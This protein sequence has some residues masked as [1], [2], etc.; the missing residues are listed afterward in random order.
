MLRN[1]FRVDL[2]YDG[3][4]FAGFARQ[5]GQRTVEGQ[6]I[7]AWR[8]L[9]PAL[10]GVQ[11]GGRTDKGVHALRQ[12]VSFW[13]RRQL[14]LQA[15]EQAAEA[16][17][18]GSGWILSCQRVARSFHAKFSA[19]ARHYMY[20]LGKDDVPWAGALTAERAAC[21]DAMLGALVGVR[22]L[23]AFARR[24]PPQA[25]PVRHILFAG[26]RLRPG[27]GIRIDVLSR[28]FLRKQMRVTVATVLRESD[29]SDDVLALVRLANT[30]D[31]QATAP[32]APADG[33]YLA[34]IIYPE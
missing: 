28:G 18:G 31:R 20:L 12:T 23:S 8:P 6:L 26:A 13:S 22:H 21:M 27:G 11:C 5:P 3:S 29:A 10:R 15:I 14:S 7:E 1:T 30:A 33:L 16:A 24:T 32:P 34:Q 17:L 4:A 25:K 19:R 2:A 9:V